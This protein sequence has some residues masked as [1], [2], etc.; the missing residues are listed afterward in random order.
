M[1]KDLPANAGDTG[2]VP[3]PGRSHSCRATKP[4]RHNYGAHEL[5]LLG[6]RALEPVLSNERSHHNEKPAHPNQ[7]VA[8][9]RCS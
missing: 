1:A 2:S 4:M 3:D 5:Q 8:A 7:R 9:A 6:L